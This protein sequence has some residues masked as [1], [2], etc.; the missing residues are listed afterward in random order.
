MTLSGWESHRAGNFNKRNLM[1]KNNEQIMFHATCNVCHYQ[2]E[3]TAAI[4]YRRIGCPIGCGRKLNMEG[5]KENT[6]VISDKVLVKG[7]PEV[8][9]LMADLVK[10]II[11]DDDKKAG[12]VSVALIVAFARRADRYLGT[13]SL[14]LL[15]VKESIDDI[16][17]ELSNIE[18][19]IDASN[20]N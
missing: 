16:G 1:E 17:T 18:K 13:L 2:L 15:A 10:A 8:G 6:M 20:T 14:N 9:I 12:E 3:N 19:V 5:G 4:V 11:A 7:E